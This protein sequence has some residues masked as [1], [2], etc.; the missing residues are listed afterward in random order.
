MQ[1]DNKKLYE[2]NI[3]K[4]F[5]IIATSMRVLL[6]RIGMILSKIILIFKIKKGIIISL[7]K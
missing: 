4:A 7:K 5:Q 3:D 2:K 1:E 6:Q